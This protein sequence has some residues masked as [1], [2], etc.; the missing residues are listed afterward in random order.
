[1][2]DTIERPRLKITYATL[3][4]DNDELHAQF[5]KG[6]EEA[7]AMLGQNHRNFV[8]GEPSGN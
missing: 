8:D 5:E 4:N 6:V 7:R 2:T 1:M 3:R